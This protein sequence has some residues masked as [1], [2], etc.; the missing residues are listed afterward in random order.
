ML[1]RLQKWKYTVKINDILLDSP[2]GLFGAI[3]CMHSR[4]LKWVYTNP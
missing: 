4:P 2:T 3:Y 1:E